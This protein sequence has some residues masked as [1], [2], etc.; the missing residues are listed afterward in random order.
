MQKSDLSLV[1]VLFEDNHLIAVNKPAGWLVQPD[2]TGDA[3]LADLVKNWIKVRHQKPGN[4]Y[5]GTIHRL[6]RP[7]TGICVF[8]K[9]SKALS[10]MNLLFQKRKV[11]KVYWAITT[12]RPEPFEN[13]LTHYLIKDREKNV[14]RTLD[15]LSNRNPD[16]KKATLSY[17]LLSSIDRHHLLEVKPETGRS[18]QI[19]AQLASINCP[20]RGD[21]KY[22]SNK[23]P[24]LDGSI[25]LHARSLAFEHPV[26]KEPI[27][28]EADPYL[29]PLWGK[30]KDFFE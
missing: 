22:G 17:K 5:L 27:Y 25:Y 28:L 14:T 30:F 29:N 16:A 3:T 24:E 23:H 9:T 20:I 6:D 4:V 10:R 13:S 7:V 18:H 21:L 19:R 11:D 1:K 12:Q 8:A 15:R 26:K 2:E